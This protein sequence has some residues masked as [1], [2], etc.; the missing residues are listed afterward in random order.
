M[1]P[2]SYIVDNPN[3][4]K[5]IILI[6]LITPNNTQ[7]RGMIN[8]R[9]KQTLLQSRL[10]QGRKQCEQDAEDK[11]FT[12]WLLFFKQTVHRGLDWF[13]WYGRYYTAHVAFRIM[14]TFAIPQ[15]KGKMYR[16]ITN[17]LSELF[18]TQFIKKRLEQT[19]AI[20][21]QDTCIPDWFAFKVMTKFNKN[22]DLSRTALHVSLT[23][24]LLS[25]LGS[26]KV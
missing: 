25:F 5:E 8:L 19:T 22:A 12:G 14:K 6:L 21:L 11:Y 1:F 24:V 16:A 26:T 17:E 13:L 23:A 4:V 10:S 7:R 2:F 9:T 18:L 3:M 15:I 20:N